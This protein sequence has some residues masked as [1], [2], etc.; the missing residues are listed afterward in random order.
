MSQ[1]IAIPD[2]NVV[3][4]THGCKENRWDKNAMN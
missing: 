4:Y 1:G 2:L 3:Q